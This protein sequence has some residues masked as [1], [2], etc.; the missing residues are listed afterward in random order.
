MLDREPRMRRQIGAPLPFLNHSGSRGEG[1]RQ[2]ARCDAGGWRLE[3]GG[4]GKSAENHRGDGRQHP[5]RRFALPARRHSP[6]DKEEAKR[7]NG[8]NGD[9]GL[10]HQRNDHESGGQQ[11]RRKSGRP[12]RLGAGQIWPKPGIS[13]PVIHQGHTNPVPVRRYSREIWQSDF[14]EG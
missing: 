11:Q 14:K 12:Q 7:E 1:R 8:G 5:C 4:S 9:R 3:H 13:D 10:G 2:G 6:C